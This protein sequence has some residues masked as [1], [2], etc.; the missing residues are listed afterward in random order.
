MRSV[1][2][3]LWILGAMTLWSAPQDRPNVLFIMA[4]DLRSELG[5]MAAKNTMSPPKTSNA[6]IRL[7]NN[8]G[9]SF[10][11]GR[12]GKYANPPHL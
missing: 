11:C 12:M 8:S 10:P 1:L 2:V 9:N 7:P 6:P 5:Y 4:N 3:L